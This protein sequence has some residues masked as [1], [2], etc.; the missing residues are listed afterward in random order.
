MPSPASAARPL[1]VTEAFSRR[2]EKAMVVSAVA[3]ARAAGVAEAMIEPTT[4]IWPR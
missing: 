4:Q 2:G 1:P 3:H